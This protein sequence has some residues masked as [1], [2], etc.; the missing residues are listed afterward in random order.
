M[1]TGVGRVADAA[2]A[3]TLV[4]FMLLMVLALFDGSWESAEDAGG[5]SVP[6]LPVVEASPVAEAGSTAA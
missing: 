2:A 3:G 4:T 6:T 1:A 5:P